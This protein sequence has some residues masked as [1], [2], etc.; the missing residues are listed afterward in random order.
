MG[1]RQGKSNFLNCII[2]FTSYFVLNVCN[3]QP[4]NEPVGQ[5]FSKGNRKSMQEK[6]TK[7]I[8]RVS[9]DAGCPVDS[10][11]YLIIK[12]YTVF[13]TKPCRHL[14]KVVTFYACGQERTYYHGA[15][16]GA[17]LYWLLGSWTYLKPKENKN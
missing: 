4:I 8:Q 17:A 13:Y 10:I 12:K 9:R 2:L 6:M 7:L 3:A 16:S 15:I 1:T 5:C 14:P 11:T